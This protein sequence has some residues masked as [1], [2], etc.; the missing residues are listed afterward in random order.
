MWFYDSS[1]S[2]CFQNDSVLHVHVQ[3]ARA[4]ESGLGP[5]LFP[6]TAED[7]TLSRF[8]SSKR[9][10][11][12]NPSIV[13]HIF[14]LI[15][16][17]HDMPLSL[18]LVQFMT[19]YGIILNHYSFKSI[20]RGLSDFCWNGTKLWFDTHDSIRSFYC[21]LTYDTDTY[22][23]SVS[24]LRHTQTVFFKRNSRYF[25]EKVVLSPPFRVIRLSE[26]LAEETSPKPFRRS[27]PPNVIVP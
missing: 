9:R 4:K 16:I 14:N 2:L 27:R 22:I 3:A 15:L 6:Q 20:I 25:N 8:T 12:T 19:L 13:V 10:S 17:Y 26:V 18:L 7:I 24:L 11:L 5:H 23:H 21:V 1:Q